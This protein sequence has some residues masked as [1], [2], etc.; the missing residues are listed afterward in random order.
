METLIAAPVLVD[1]KRTNSQGKVK[2]KLSVLGVRVSNCP[3]CLSQFRG[4]DLAV[5]LPRC[6]HVAHETC[7]KRWFKE[8]DTCMVCREPL[9]EA[10][11]DH[12]IN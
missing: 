11:D 8:G 7:A 3:I 10:D 9:I 6:G 1:S 5:L 4:T 2:L 12:D